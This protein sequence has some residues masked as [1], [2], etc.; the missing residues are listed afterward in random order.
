MTEDA[1]IKAWASLIAA[2]ALHVQAARSTERMTTTTMLLR[3]SHDLATEGSSTPVRTGIFGSGRVYLRPRAGGPEVLVF[4][5]ISTRYEHS[6]LMRAHNYGAQRSCLSV[7]WST[8]SAICS[9][10]PRV[11]LLK[12]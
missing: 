11:A 8:W 7:P 4:S 3:T 2:M 6:H 5:L 9:R 12:S 10:V 1:A